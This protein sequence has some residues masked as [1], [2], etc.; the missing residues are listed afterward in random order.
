MANVA[1]IATPRN[2]GRK[3]CVILL[4]FFFGNWNVQIGFQSATTAVVAHKHEAISLQLVLRGCHL[5]ICCPW[6]REDAVASIS[7]FA[8]FVRLYGINVGSRVVTNKHALTVLCHMFFIQHGT[9]C[10]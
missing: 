10:G 8:T 4:S 7:Y 6:H 3:L 1:A 5:L 9:A 2:I